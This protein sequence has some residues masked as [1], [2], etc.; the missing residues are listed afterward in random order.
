[1]AA[2]KRPNLRGIGANT[3]FNPTAPDEASSQQDSKPVRQQE[4]NPV[5]PQL[6]KATFYLTPAQIVKLEQI[7]LARIEKGQKIDKSALVRE[8]ID[9][10]ASKPA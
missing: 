5:S 3:Y 4:G 7:R 8:A 1:M 6:V 9:Q 10:L 2:R